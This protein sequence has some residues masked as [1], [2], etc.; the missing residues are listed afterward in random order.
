[1]PNLP[2][3]RCSELPRVLFCNGSLGASRRV[4]PRPDDDSSLEGVA[5]HWLA[6]SRIKDEL[7]AEGDIG[8]E[9]AMPNSILMNRWI[10]DFY[11]RVVKEAVPEDWSIV[12]EDSWDHTFR[13][14]RLTGHPDDN[15]LSPD[16]TEMIGLD[17]KAVYNPVEEA[18]GN[19]QMLGYAALAKLRYPKLRKLTWFVVQPRIDEEQTG[20]Q[21][22][23]FATLEGGRIEN[24][25]PTLESRINTALDNPMELLR[26]IKGC[27]WC[28]V[29]LSAQ[30][31]EL[32]SARKELLMKMT[33]EQ[34]AAIKATPDDATLVEWG[35]DARILSPVIESATD[36][37]KE[38]VRSLGSLPC[39]DGVI[40][41]KTTKG[42]YSVLDD[43]AFYAAH[44]RALPNEA[45]YAATVKPVVG[46]IKDKLA[47][48]RGI[49]RKGK[50]V[51]AD[52][53]FDAEFG[54][55]VEQGTRE[56]LVWP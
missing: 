52:T 45:D 24:V 19:E 26:S 8:P 1:M 14:F 51:N 5:L 48:T 11:F 42:T 9:P 40:T 10:A 6:H 55:L 12:C 13:R 38:R 28:P 53:V 31:P 41:M 21:R 20:V 18:S 27:R 46:A 47:E 37:L 33:P 32:I 29:G 25:V 36:M 43:Q 50:G 54:H 4:T 23:S 35:R 49:S 39:G 17:L 15:A 3:L 30:C 56:Q 34:L 16:E 22:V 2:T 44:R 7:G